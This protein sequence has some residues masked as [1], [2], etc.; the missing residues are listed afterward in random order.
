MQIH[1][2]VDQPE[3]ECLLTTLIHAAGSEWVCD[4]KL[5]DDERETIDR[6]YERFHDQL[7]ELER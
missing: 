7:K 1:L 4:T 5:S 2:I 6:L 3:L